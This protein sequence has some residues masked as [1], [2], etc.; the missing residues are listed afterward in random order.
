MRSARRNVFFPAAL[1]G[2]LIENEVSK[3]DAVVGIRHDGCALT[4]VSEH[5]KHRLKALILTDM[6]EQ[7]GPRLIPQEKPKAHPVSVLLI[8]QRDLFDVLYLDFEHLARHCFGEHTVRLTTLRKRNLDG[9][10]GEIC[11]SGP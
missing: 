5:H 9:E 4:S 10:L 7:I 8:A 2:N 3:H 11:R 6:A 1:L